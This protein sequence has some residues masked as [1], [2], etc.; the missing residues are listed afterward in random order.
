MKADAAKRSSTS[1]ARGRG[2]YATQ[3]CSICRGK[4]TKCDGVKPVCGP[5]ANTGRHDEC[6]W[7]RESGRKPRTEAHFE[8]MRKRA[9]ALEE[10]V[11]L[12]ESVLEKCRREHGGV[13]DNGQSYLQFRPVDAEGMILPDEIEVDNEDEGE[14]QMLAQELCIPTRNLKLEEGNLLLHGNT[15][16]FRFAP[17]SAPIAP[18][19]SRFPHISESPKYVLLVDGVEDQSY[20]PDFDWSRYLP[21]SVPLGRREHD[22]LLDLLFK[23]FTSWCLRI[24]P[25][26]F[27]R[28]MHRALSGHRSQ[29]PPKTTHYSPML[30]NALISVA[31]AFSDDP[32]IRDLQS[33]QAFAIAAKSYIEAECQQPNISVMH[34]LSVIGSYHSGLGEQ[35][36]GY[37]YFGMSARISQALGL[38]IDCSAWVKSGLISEHDMFDRNW[39]HWTIFTQDVCWSLYVGRDFS[40]PSSMESK[41]I[42]IPFVDSDFDSIPW[43]YPPSGI[44]PQPNFLSTTFAASCQLLMIAR[45][46]MDVVNGLNNASVRHEINDELISNID[47]Q[48]NTWKSN[49]TPDLDITLKSR[50]TAT[51]HRLMMHCTYW[52]FFILLHR[53]FYHRRPRPLHSSDREI[54]HVKLCKRAAENIVEL[55][56]TWRSLYTLRYAPITLVQTAFSAGTIYLL[57]AVQAATGLRVAQETLRHALFQ[58]QL[59]VQYLLEIGKSWQ[60]ATNIA[61]ILRNLLQEQ[62]KPLLERRAINQGPLTGQLGSPT[63]SSSSATRHVFKPPSTERRRSPSQRRSTSRAE[64]SR[65]RGRSSVIVPNDAMRSVSTHHSP[66]SP[67]DSPVSFNMQSL[68]SSSSSSASPRASAPANPMAFNTHSWSLDFGNTS[69]SNNTSSSSSSLPSRDSSM[70]ENPTPPTFLTGGDFGL[71]M[72]IGFGTHNSNNVNMGH[73]VPSASA[74][75]DPSSFL[76]MLGGEPLSNAPFL[77]TFDSYSPPVL[78]SPSFTHGQPPQIYGDG[79]PNTRVQVGMIPDSE[80]AILTQFWDQNFG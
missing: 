35:T 14:D 36:L 43:H 54:D 60:C 57:V 68:R 20:N 2:T 79:N 32:R 58:A 44:P 23:F 15:A 3:A 27:L 24:V 75:M 42:P 77:P 31:T 52:W 47:L 8:A 5:C 16:V 62:L 30:H 10:Y 1:T 45:R 21:S 25:D 65:S 55:L 33:R 7:G 80:L 18:S 9:D 71:G 26:L 64:G 6:S 46:I 34:A 67:S 38:S 51:P 41:R 50:P 48:L 29:T 19:A 28:D 37:L 39:A 70:G 61:E 22:K 11:N 69:N 78:D 66:I 76:A 53:P 49:L 12:L 17:E 73:T 74:G 40:I 13:S 72:N 59:C 63:A 4:K 56:G